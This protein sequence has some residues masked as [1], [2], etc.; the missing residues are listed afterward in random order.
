MTGLWA[1]LRR[2]LAEVR[3]YLV[4][5]GLALFGLSYLSVYR[6]RAVERLF[7]SAEAAVDAAPDGALA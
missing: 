3:I 2:Q 7:E 5:Y 6:T 4:F 1:L